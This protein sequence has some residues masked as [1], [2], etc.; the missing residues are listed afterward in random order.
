MA[1][2]YLGS[3]FDIH[4]GGL[5]LIFPHHENEI[6]QSLAVGDRFANYW[7]HNAW[8]T[9]S[10]E[11]MSKSLN[12]SLLVDQMVQQWRPVELRYYLGAAHYRSN[13][14]YSEAALNEAATAYQRIEGFLTRAGKSGGGEIGAGATVPAAFAAALDD[15]LAVPAALAVLHDT[16]RQGNAALAADDQDATERHYGE[17]RAMVA[18]LGIDPPG[19]GQQGAAAHAALDALV[20]VVLELRQAARERKD[21]ATSDAIRDGLGAAGIV[22]EDTASGPRWTLR[23]G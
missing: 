18:V 2:K 10:G 7:M 15:D 3:Q 14:E 6:A 16:V 8:V 22:I 4:G 21:Y 1:S 5:D 13:I 11:K 23:E 9:I 20:P 17:V 12:N 19:L